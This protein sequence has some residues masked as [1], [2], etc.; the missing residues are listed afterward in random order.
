M[1]KTSIKTFLVLIH[2][3]DNEMDKLATKG[4]ELI[5]QMND[6]NFSSITD[7]SNEEEL[8]DSFNNLGDKFA[9]IDNMKQTL[10]GGL[11]RGVIE[12]MN[13]NSPSSKIKSLSVKRKNKLNS[14]RKTRHAKSI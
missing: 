6:I 13:V 12:K 7:V 9:A 2:E 3:L 1:P 10:L 5:A 8:T 4:E 11:R 14:L